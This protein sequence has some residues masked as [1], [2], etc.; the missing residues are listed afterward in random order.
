MSPLFEIYRRKLFESISAKNR[1]EQESEDALLDELD[2]IWNKMTE[3]ERVFAKG[4]PFLEQYRGQ[5]NYFVAK[6]VKLSTPWT[7]PSYSRDSVRNVRIV[8]SPVVAW[9]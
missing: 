2:D 3:T 5:F 8:S 4:Y 7:L 1:G 6:Q 9:A